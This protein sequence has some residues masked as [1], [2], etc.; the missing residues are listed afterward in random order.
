MEKN[1]GLPSSTGLK[2]DEAGGDTAGGRR[3]SRN[4]SSDEDMDHAI[5]WEAERTG[6]SAAGFSE[7]SILTLMEFMALSRADAIQVCSRLHQGL[8]H[9]ISLDMNC[10]VNWKCF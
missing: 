2:R 7:A 9:H 6:A 4:D 3:T 1:E 5:G 10:F 8:F